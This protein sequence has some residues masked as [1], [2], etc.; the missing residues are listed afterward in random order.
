MTCSEG[1]SK[2]RAAVRRLG[3]A[4]HARLAGYARHLAPEPRARLLPEERLEA[5]LVSG[6][7]DAV[8]QLLRD[9]PSGLADERRRYLLSQVTQGGA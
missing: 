5:L 4:D 8:A 3:E 9:E 2:G 6:D 7:Q 1:R